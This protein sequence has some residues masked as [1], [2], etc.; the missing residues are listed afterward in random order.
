MGAVARAELQ[1]GYDL[2]RRRRYATQ[3]TAK[4]SKLPEHVGG[5]GAPWPAGDAGPKPQV[6]PFTS[7]AAALRKVK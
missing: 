7:L 6:K 1:R 4:P 2:M 3:P 5:S